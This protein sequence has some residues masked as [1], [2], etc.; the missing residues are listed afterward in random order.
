MNL[1]Y[2]TAVL[3]LLTLGIVPASSFGP[4]GG[5]GHG[6]GGGRPQARQAPHPT[7]SH[8]RPAPRPTQTPKPAPR[9]APA[10]RPA[11]N[12]RPSLGPAHTPKPA[13]RPA[14]NVP[15]TRPNPPSVMP[16]IGSGDDRPAIGG[17]T[18]PA[19]LPIGPGGKDR[20]VFPDGKGGKG[21]L[22]PDGK[23]GK[24]RPIFP[25]GKDGKGGLFPD[26]KGGKDRP[27][28]PDGKDGKG[29]LF[30]DGK[31]DWPDGKKDGWRPDRPIRPDV[32]RPIIG[33]GN[34]NTIINRPGGGNNNTIVNRPNTNI[35]NRVVNNNVN[36]INVNQWNQ[37]NQRVYAGRPG[38][39]TPANWNRPWYGGRP[40]WY[41]SR[42]WYNYHAGWHHGFWNF[43]SAPPAIW[44][45]G[46]VAAGWLMSPGDTF[47]YSNPYYVVPPPS[48][49]VVVQQPNYAEP[50]PAPTPTQ[51]L[52]AYPPD[53]EVGEDGTADLKPTDAPPP[54]ATD[55]PTVTDANKTFDAAREAFKQGQYARAQ[56]LADQAIKELLSDGTLHEFRSLALFAQGKYKDAA[57][58]LYAVLAAGPG[59]DWDTMRALYPNTETYTTQLR[60]LEA[61]VGKEPSA[62][63]GHFL[64][65][66]HYLVVVD[67][68]AA[69][70][71][72]QDVVKV[73]PDDKLSAALVKALT[74]DPAKD[75]PPMPGK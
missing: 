35:G 1:K 44:F 15:K 40:A 43:W 16:K 2:C 34:N 65:A 48:T 27:I 42:P 26:G 59:W 28:F 71:Q 63:Y 46:G 8:S 55:D 10:A 12:P 68:A 23:G 24:D 74:S 30:P 6:G 21:G 73:Q 9:P 31:K 22:F 69:V 58:G 61:F 32:D 57:A 66:Y 64:L 50:L 3:A 19:P 60:A 17:K 70:R 47:V 45:G 11:N 37:Y 51:R 72:F 54:T 52:A 5:G 39:A 53:P 18:R 67:K 4:R 14:V 36:N 56:E 25:D 41:Y 7:P 33:G 62:G 75:G 38:W 29:G 49:T 20:P 13:P